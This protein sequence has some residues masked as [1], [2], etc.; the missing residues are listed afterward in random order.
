M[1][2]RRILFII[3][4][5]AGIRSKT[6]IEALCGQYLDQHLFSPDYAYTQHAG[7]GFQLSSENRSQYDT[8]VA[9]GGDG[10][11]NEI[12]QALIHND[13]SLGII[14]LGSGNGLARHLKIPLD[15]R[16]SIKHINNSSLSSIDTCTF[17]GKPF[18]CT[19]G[20]GFE[21]AVSSAFDKAPSRGL[22]TYLRVIFSL[23]KNHQ[24]LTINLPA[25]L[26]SESGTFSLTFANAEQFGN[27][28]RIAPTAS[29]TDGIIDVCHLKPFPMTAMAS[30]AYKM[31]RGTIK[32]SK[33]YSSIGKP[34]LTIEVPPNTPCHIDGDPIIIA[35]DSITVKVLPK[36]LKILS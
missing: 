23:I 28:A 21:A 35:S 9:V 3:N 12:A 5:I 7:H 33:Y 27:N 13:C 6:N 1:R 32:T 25:E 24:P 11:I 31:V 22:L 30:I 4:P 14:P 19:A 36:S 8:I 18:L 10:T 26:T 29:L 16:E 15:T 2:K 34:N 17:N 20:I